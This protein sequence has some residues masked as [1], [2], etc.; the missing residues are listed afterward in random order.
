MIFSTTI[1]SFEHI[2]SLIPRTHS[3][4]LEDGKGSTF[5][6]INTICLQFCNV[7]IFITNSLKYYLNEIGVTN[8]L[9]E[10]HLKSF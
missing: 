4:H 1:A 3:T 5:D 7:L 10:P 8:C 9:T 2:H 6:N